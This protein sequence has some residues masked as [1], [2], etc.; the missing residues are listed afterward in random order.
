MRC[1]VMQKEIVRLICEKVMLIAIYLNSSDVIQ[2]TGDALGGAER[3]PLGRFRL[4]ERRVLRVH[5]EP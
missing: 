2:L 4:L 1:L 5:F 3:L